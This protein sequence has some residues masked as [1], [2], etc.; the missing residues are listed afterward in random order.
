MTQG[1]TRIV[2]KSPAVRRIYETMKH[3]SPRD[4]AQCICDVRGEHAKVPQSVTRGPVV[5]AV[6]SLGAGGTERQLNVAVANM[7]QKIDDAKILCINPKV[8][9]TDFFADGLSTDRIEVVW[10]IGSGEHD[11]FFAPPSMLRCVRYLRSTSL[12]PEVATTVLGFI[13]QFERFK[14][15]VVHSWLDYTNVSAGLAAVLSGVPRIVLGCRSMAPFHF[16]L[17]RP[18]FHPIYNLLLRSPGVVMTTNSLAGAKD[19]ASWLGISLS[20][21]KVIHNAFDPSAVVKP[22]LEELGAFRREFKLGSDAVVGTVGRLADEKRPFLW[23]EVACEVLK[24][25]P[26]TKFIWVGG[27]PVE[28]LLRKEIASLGIGDRVIVTGLRKDV[29]T[30]LSAFSVFLL[31]SIQE[32]LPNVLIEAQAHGLPVVSAAVGGAPETFQEGVTGLGV[33]GSRAADYAR[34]VTHFLDDAGAI[35]LAKQRGPL[36]VR[37]RFSVDDVVDQMLALYRLE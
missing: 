13:S 14:P 12:P 37:E 7:K 4:L 33:R 11:H 16:P 9:S 25:R 2:I 5:H 27:G 30:A 17:Y 31:T 10:N 34:A 35:A 24:R 29:G 1:L 6:G 21:I 18:Y 20:E 8:E 28:A 22:S 3:I 15:R 36:L 32:G 19:Y 26:R 23:L